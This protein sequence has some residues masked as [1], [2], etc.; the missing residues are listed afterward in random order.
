ML[1][2]ISRFVSAVGFPIAITVYLLHFQ[3]KTINGLKDVINRNTEILKK[4]CDKV[5]KSNE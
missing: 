5:E 1:D 3:S 4:L 2:E